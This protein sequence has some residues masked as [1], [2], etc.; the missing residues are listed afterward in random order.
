MNGVGSRQPRASSSSRGRW[1]EVACDPSG[2]AY[3]HHPQ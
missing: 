1:A 2:E 3:P